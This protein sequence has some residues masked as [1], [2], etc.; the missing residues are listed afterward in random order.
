MV[1]E[2][3]IVI[4]TERPEVERIEIA[5]ELSR[6]R[7]PLEI[8]PAMAGMKGGIARRVTWVAEDTHGHILNHKSR[9]FECGSLA[10]QGVRK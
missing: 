6:R 2:E 4:A 8:Y 7:F 9:S 5:P 10:R 3:A 1:H